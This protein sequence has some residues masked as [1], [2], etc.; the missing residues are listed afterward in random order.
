MCYCYYINWIIHTSFI[1]PL[2]GPIVQVRAWR[3][4]QRSFSI[5]DSCEQHRIIPMALDPTTLE[6]CPCTFFCGLPRFLPSLAAPCSTSFASVL[7]LVV[8]PNHWSF[9]RF[10]VAKSGYSGPAASVMSCITDIGYVVYVRNVHDPSEIVY[11]KC[12]YSSF[13][14]GFQRPAFASVCQH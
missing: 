8:L 2:T 13:G 10:T 11:L 3:L 4:P 6:C 12:G 14:L 5:W 1:H 9:R 7:C